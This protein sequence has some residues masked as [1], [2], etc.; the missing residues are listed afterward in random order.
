MFLVSATIYAVNLLLPAKR[1]A[2]QIKTTDKNLHAIHDAII[3]FTAINGHLPCPANPLAANAGNSDP[4]PSSVICSS[5]GGVVPWATLAIAPDVALDGWNRRISFR[6]FDGAT[7]LTRPGGASMVNCDV[8]VT[9]PVPMAPEDLCNVTHTNLAT[10][11]LAG[12]GLTVNAL[13]NI[14]SGVAFVLIS[15]GESGNGAYLPEGARV[16]APISVEEIA[17]T[18]SA[19]PYVRNSHSAPGIDSLDAAHFD[20]IVVWATINELATKSG[21]GPR[22]WP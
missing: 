16:Q 9:S 13:G 1:G 19:G 20:D 6:V 12:K 2:H 21:L 4:S 8:A 17:N 15:H 7:G 11:F 10:D 5:P 3:A 22:D 14:T 18:N